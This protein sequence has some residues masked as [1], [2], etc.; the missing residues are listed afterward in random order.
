I[1]TRME[2]ES[3]G[4]AV[5]AL[6][7]LPL[8]DYFELHARLGFFGT[9]TKAS[10]G[11]GTPSRPVELSESGFSFSFQFGAGAAVNIGDH[12]SLSADWVHYFAVDNGGGGEEEDDL[13][14]DGYDVDLLRL[15]A[16]VRF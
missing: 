2:V 7:N 5:S 16:I 3:Q 13:D 1:T 4:V 11:G 14:Y 10:G 6:G 15:S 12:F 9:E 8:S